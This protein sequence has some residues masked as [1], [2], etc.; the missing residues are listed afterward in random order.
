[1]PCLAEIQHG[2]LASCKSMLDF[3]QLPSKG[4][5]AM[6]F[7]Q[8]STDLSFIRH[9]F[10]TPAD[11][12]AGSTF[13]GK[14][15]AIIRRTLRRMQVQGADEED[16]VH[17]TLHRIVAHFGKFKRRRK[18]AFRS[19]VRRVA[20]S[21]VVEWHRK[22]PVIAFFQLPDF[23]KA[24]ARTLSSELDV[25]LAEATVSAVRLE[26]HP[27]QWE[28]FDRLRLQ[29]QSAESIASL[30]GLTPFAVYKA[31]YRVGQRLR[32]VRARL[33]KGL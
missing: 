12:A 20:R 28:M 17:D 31:A 7:S 19:W 10:L 2:T 5:K 8:S 23:A 6:P 13:Y 30:H 32:E 9:S 24:L 4:L 11:L 26:V 21:A 27:L 3:Q 15:S 33:E 16:L 22:N 14:Y 29:G 25:D 18:G 1:M